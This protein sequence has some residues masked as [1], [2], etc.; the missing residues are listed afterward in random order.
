M[1]E[2]HKTETRSNTLLNSRL[3]LHQP[4]RGYRAAIDPVF[5]AA[6]APAQPGMAVMD[7]GCGVGTAALCLASRVEGLNITGIDIQDQLA[8]LARRNAAEN[9][10]ENACRFLGGDITAP[11]RD[12]VETYNSHDIVISNPPFMDSASHSPSPDVMR[13]TAH[14]TGEA[15]LADWVGFAAKMLKPRGR[16]VMVHRAD[17]IDRILAAFSGRFGGVCI[18]PLWP[19]SGRP[20]KRVIIGAIKG[21]KAP[22]QMLPGMII[23]E[24]DAARDYTKQARAILYDMA[25][26][27]LWP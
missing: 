6:A 15:T 26:I 16:L 12:I 2:S 27:D 19:R 3:S 22:A 10:L 4:V 25:G 5:L 21:A 14:T 7:A 20:A 24:G 8:D 18:F 9:G 17:H 23:H 13:N 11:S 1:T